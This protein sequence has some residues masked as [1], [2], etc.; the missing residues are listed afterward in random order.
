MGVASRGLC[1]GPITRPEESCR[2]W[3]GGV[4]ECDLESSTR[5]PKSTRAVK[6]WKKHITTVII[7]CI[8]LRVFRMK[9]LI[10]TT[11]ET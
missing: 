3:Y 11:F 4:A 10:E 7:K 5:R 8:V 2:V 1:D 9:K 6:S